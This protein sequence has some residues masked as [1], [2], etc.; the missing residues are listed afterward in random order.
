VLALQ[1]RARRIFFAA[2]HPA[3]TSVAATTAD[4]GILA[5][6]GGARF[7]QSITN[8]LARDVL[9][10]T[11]QEDPVKAD[12]RDS[13]LEALLQAAKKAPML[14]AEEELRLAKEASAGSGAGFERL[15]KSHLRLVLTI[16]HEFSAYGLPLDDL[17]SEGLLGLVEAARR[18]DPERGVRLAAYAAWWI[19]AYM[20]RYTIFNRRIVR[21]PSSRHGR[22]L[23][24]NLRRI[25]R[26]VAQTTG[27]RPDA[28]TVA[29]LLGVGVRDVEEMEA[30]LSGR[31]IPCGFDPEG[32]AMD[33]PSE[34]PSPEVLVAETEEREWSMNAVN[35]AMRTLSRRERHILQKRY[36][37][38]ESSSLASIGR[39]MGLSRERVRQLEHQAQAKMREA[40]RASA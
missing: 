9:H 17:V 29:K 6:F 3:R 28:E 2:R 27:E 31:D 4:A 40:I 8:M 7:A 13:G 19:R 12:N 39:G 1:S 16:A 26:E 11:A 14:T 38:E 37:T 15:L 24:A 25:Q 35:E 36:L 5:K 20:R 22:K 32:R 18:Y 21:T 30:A 34:G 10:G 33:L 23:L